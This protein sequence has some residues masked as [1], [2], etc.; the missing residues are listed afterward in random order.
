MRQI[1]ESLATHQYL[2]RIRKQDTIMNN[3]KK[4]LSRVLL[5]PFLFMKD[6]TT[7]AQA[8]GKPNILV[9]WCDD[10]GQ[11]NISAYTEI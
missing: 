4:V 5:L 11:S 6:V 7:A 2:H 10:I 3:Y 8:A 9:N 1:L